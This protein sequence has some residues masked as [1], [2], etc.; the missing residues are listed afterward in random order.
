MKNLMI[1]A[2]NKAN[3]EMYSWEQIDQVDYLNEMIFCGGTDPESGK[4][5]SKE[6]YLEDVELL[7]YTGLEDNSNTYIFEGDI[8]FHQKTGE[9]Y[10]VVLE[11]GMFFAKGKNKN[12]ELYKIA[13]NSFVVG[14]IYEHPDIIRRGA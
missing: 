1:K 4:D 3:R 8:V 9:E 14:N 10:D 7:L 6:F 11:L 5:W 2:W 13:D 12:F